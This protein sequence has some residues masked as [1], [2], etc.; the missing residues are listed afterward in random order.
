MIKLIRSYKVFCNTR[1]NIIA[2]IVTIILAA[3]HCLSATISNVLQFSSVGLIIVLFCLELLG[4]YFTFRGL[5]S[6]KYEFGI[7]RNSVEG[8][9]ILKL[10]VFGDQL[11]RIS[12][13][14]II[15][16][17]NLWDYRSDLYGRGIINSDI[18]M[19]AIVGCVA[20]A[21]YVEITATFMITRMLSSVYAYIWAAMIGMLIY[22]F[23]AAAIFLAVLRVE[24]LYLSWI[25][26]FI[27]ALSISFM[28][29]KR[30]LYCFKRS[31][32]DNIRR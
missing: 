11:I 22:S 31:F 6:S 14:L 17:F 29:L 20:C 21:F 18:Q 1:Y 19:A 5:A 7:F 32:G 25:L 8:G 26:S 2:L 13:Y 16:F 23:G 24:N 4:D 30:I 3:W 10:A 27:L 12:R 9:K 15:A 28:M